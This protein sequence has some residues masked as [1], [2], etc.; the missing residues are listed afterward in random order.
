MFEE[1]GIN[2]EYAAPEI[3]E[4]GDRVIILMTVY[5]R[6]T[7]AEEK[8]VRRGMETARKLLEKMRDKSSPTLDK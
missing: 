1:Y 5:E 7:A 2:D 4:A 3:Y 6:D 8:L